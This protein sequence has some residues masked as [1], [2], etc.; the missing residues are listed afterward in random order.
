MN[1]IRVLASCVSAIEELIVLLYP[2]IVVI[3]CVPVFYY[4]NLD[5]QRLAF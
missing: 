5:K 1:V 3:L 4:N 2:D